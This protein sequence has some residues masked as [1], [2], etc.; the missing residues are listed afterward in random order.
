MAGRPE[1]PTNTASQH[2]ETKD[3]TTT[4]KNTRI[5]IKHLPPAL[6]DPTKLKNHLFNSRQQYFR[7][8]P[9]TVTDCK[10]LAKRRMAF[11]GCSTVEASAACVH[12]LHRSYF[13][14]TQ[15][16]VE[17]A[18]PPKETVTKDQTPTTEPSSS[19]E[20]YRPPRDTKLIAKRDDKKNQ[21]L[22]AM[23]A[24]SE[25]RSNS[26][27]WS[28]DDG[29][30][31]DV[32]PTSTND[33]SAD[34]ASNQSE[35]SDTDEDDADAQASST[36]NSL[37]KQT[38]SDFL[39]SKTVAAHD[40]DEESTE[41]INHESNNHISDDEQDEITPMKP[42]HDENMENKADDESEIQDA[43]HGTG[44]DESRTATLTCANRLFVRNLAFDTSE[45]DL[46]Q[47][48]SKF[49]TVQECH[50]PVDDQRSGKGF[51][52][53]SFESPSSASSA[54]LALDGTDFQGR[55]IHILP[56]RPPAANRSP[57]NTSNLTFKERKEMDR[58]GNSANDQSGW[59]AS[60][61][62]GDAVVD[63]LAARLG[64]RK[65]EILPV[66]DGMS[67]GD[68]AVRMALAETAIIEEN[69]SYF[70]EHGI[71]MEALVSFSTN[72]HENSNVRSQTCILVK[73][74]PHDTTTDDLSKT[75]SLQTSPQRILLPPSRTVAVVEFGHAHDAK[76]AF[77][78][79]A[80]RRFKNVPLYLEWAP[81][82]SISERH[83]QQEASP[84]KSMRSIPDRDEAADTTM[85]ESRGPTTTVYVKNLSFSTTEEEL[86]AV[87]EQH[88]GDIR[89]V[90]IPMKVAPVKRTSLEMDTNSSQPSL[91][92][93]YG[94]VEF[95]SQ[96]SARMV[97]KKLQGVLVAGHSL[98]LQI[99]R[100]S[101]QRTKRDIPSRPAS[102]IMV[103]N[104]PFQA[105]RKDLLQLF[106]SFGHLKK[107][108][109]PKKFDG[110]HRG[111]AFVEFV[112]GKE[113]AAAMNALSRTHLY[114]RH[115]VLEW[116][117]GEDENQGV[118][119]NGWEGETVVRENKKVRYE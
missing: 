52:F 112:S 111:F 55:L 9:L 63:N 88:A 21:F 33:A 117:E 37:N 1:R 96:D 92:M 97:V 72:G 69:R 27:I 113:A 75:F 119:K 24:S 90:R 83:N 103:R 89:T 118:N 25:K 115:L 58:R 23:G 8:I 14:T 93:G 87:F 104:V 91:S 80:Y 3:P 76:R 36:V 67:G 53:V 11:V 46:K 84:T 108:R 43:S 102:K 86:Q 98:E 73:N 66:K 5:C 79:L 110:N 50:I 15:L 100:G 62:R 94:F 114:G 13:R 74:L 64:I 2:G 35:S 56:A 48:F 18:L 29:F 20:K 61:L 39:R 60:H 12:Y 28:N 22:E 30:V 59:C 19:R 40:L 78:R 6:I 85:E 116:A 38:D 47:F 71:D 105:N 31:E 10:V 45:Q 95:E 41:H 65:G 77:K 81:M 49:G 106:G 101:G 82:S 44:D 99:A 109:L 107:V 4:R 42:G 17:F 57:E 7:E 34:H 26:R 68:A 32:N 51:G 16:I 70:A 54:R